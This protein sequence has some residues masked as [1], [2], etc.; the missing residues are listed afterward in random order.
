MRERFRKPGDP[1]GVLAGA[2]FVLTGML[3]VALSSGWRVG[4]AAQMGPGY[5][6]MILGSILVVLGIVIA[7]R[8]HLA[9]NHTALPTVE[10]NAVFPV[11]CPIILFAAALSTLGLLISIFGLVFLTRMADRTIRPVETLALAVVLAGIVTLIFVAG[12]GVRVPLLPH[13]P[14]G[15]FG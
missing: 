15:W 3:S 14:A 4:T 11:I 10:L 13:T 2:L 1:A 8:A 6:P 12:L 5:F 9:A 7:A